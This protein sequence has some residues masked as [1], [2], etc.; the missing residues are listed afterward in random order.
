MNIKNLTKSV[1]VLA[2]GALVLASCQSK[3]V[4]DPSSKAAEQQAKYE[5]T[6]TEQFGNVASDQL[7][8]TAESFTV[9]VS[10]ANLGVVRI[11]T[12]YPTAA[13]ATYLASETLQAGTTKTFNLAKPQDVETLY[14]AFFDEDGAVVVKP[15]TDSGE[16][17]EFGDGT[18]NGAKAYGLKTRALTGST[19]TY[20]SDAADDAYASSIPSDAKEVSQYHQ[21]QSG[22]YYVSESTTKVNC[23]SGNCNIYFGSGNY[24]IKEWYTR[25]NTNVYLLP[26]ANVT[27]TSELNENY[28]GNN[29]YIAEGATLSAE[30]ISYNFQL[31]NRGTIKSKDLYLY[32]GA[33]IYNANTIEVTGEV[34]V[35]NNDAQIVNGGTLT[36]TNLSVEGS[37]SVQNL[38]TMNISEKTVVNSNG[39]GWQND[40]TYYT[41]EFLYQAGSSS[42]INNCKLTC[43]DFKMILG[44]G[45]MADKCFKLSGEASIVCKNFAM[46]IGYLLMESNSQ[47]AV[48]EKAIFGI[49]K[50]D[51]GVYGV[52]DDY[53]VFH[54]PT[55]SKG[56]VTSYSAGNIGVQEQASRSQGYEVSYYGQLV[57]ASDN[58]FAQ[59]YSGQYPYYYVD[60]ENVKMY[61]KGESTA[62]VIS[63]S[64]SQCHP[65]YNPT[66]DPTPTPDPTDPTDPDP[67]PTPDPDDPDEAQIYTVAFEDLG[68]TDDFDF[69][70]VVLYVE[71]AAGETTATVYLMAAGG[72]LAAE[73]YYGSDKLFSIGAKT[74]AQMYSQ[75]NT[76]KFNGVLDWTMITVGSDFD[77]SK[78][79][80]T[81]QF[82]ITVNNSSSTYTIN[83]NTA[84]GAQPQAIVIANEWAWPTERTNIGTAYP[85]FTSWVSDSSVDWASSPS[86]SVIKPTNWK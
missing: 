25:D 5:Q 3:D 19:F 30:K 2:C 38:E 43:D 50:A 31:Y 56:S 59:G 6:F 49:T 57:V 75:G 23:W 83:P 80:T 42:V 79:A 13:G 64:E 35:K 86:G 11:Y 74:D 20:G 37:G 78:T 82:S 4:Y 52:G 48:S 33:Y 41:G 21:T 22:N 29:W 32:A 39:C 61:V 8:N 60:E 53:A 18:S 66:D 68:S 62:K 84:A 55:I 45:N 73:V 67:E 70:D 46:G 26:G 54:A 58:H 44:D 51:Y 47:V 40:G 12:S 16:T 14:V 1:S 76:K 17:V 69:N 9:T 63:I 27:F 34:A 85:K 15:I 72:T 81:S 28:N 71:Y 36:A 65:A 24:T 7:W 10:T 77:M